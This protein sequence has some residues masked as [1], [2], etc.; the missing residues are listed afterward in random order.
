MLVRSKNEREMF[1]INFNF[2]SQE[3]LTG[4]RPFQEIDK[5]AAVILALGKGKRPHRPK[6]ILN[7]SPRGVPFWDILQKC[8][9]E[10]PGDRPTASEV[11]AEVSNKPTLSLSID[12]NGQL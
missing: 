9:A 3:I 6:K 1:D 11:E 10:V 2:I 5:D 7:Q 4:K 8:W 12:R